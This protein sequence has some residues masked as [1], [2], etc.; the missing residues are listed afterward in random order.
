MA[1]SLSPPSFHSYQ[2][3]P[4][5]ESQQRHGGYSGNSYRQV[6][7]SEVVTKERNHHVGNRFRLSS[8]KGKS[9]SSFAEAAGCESSNFHVPMSCKLNLLLIFC[10]RR[11]RNRRRYYR[12]WSARRIVRQPTSTERFDRSSQK[13]WQ[14]DLR[15][16]PPDWSL[17]SCNLPSL[18]DGAEAAVLEKP[19][20]PA[21]SR[22]RAQAR[23]LRSCGEDWEAWRIHRPDDCR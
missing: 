14:C 19:C 4:G 11:W 20:R 2:C 9:W 21:A 22:E 5:S 18:P 13:A 1:H 7:R 3:S 12:W 16:L 23:V 8:L 10:N 15:S 6:H 17:V